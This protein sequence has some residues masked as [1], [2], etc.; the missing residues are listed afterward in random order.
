MGAPARVKTEM[1]PIKFKKYKTV[2]GAARALL[3]VYEDE[4]RHC[5]GSY[6]K[7]VSG[8]PVDSPKR[9]V[10][11]CVSAGML[12]FYAGDWANASLALERACQQVFGTWEFVEVN[13]SA[14]GLERVRMIL[15]RVIKNCR[16]GSAV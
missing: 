4:Q 7:G 13:D 1:K 12:A 8:R 2:P 3:R 10:R 5:K 16:R 9:A 14:D 11:C 15:R 6:F